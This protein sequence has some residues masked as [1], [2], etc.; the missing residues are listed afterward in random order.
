MVPIAKILLRAGLSYREFDDVCRL[1][2]VQV[3]SSEFGVRN[4]STNFSRISALTGISRKE[5]SRLSAGDR[6]LDFSMRES[7]SPLADIVQTWSGNRDF[8]D[9]H[10]HPIPLP[11]DGDGITFQELV[12]RTGGDYPIGAIRK[13]LLRMKVVRFDDEG[14]VI[15]LRSDLIP[16]DLDLRVVSSLTYSLAGLAETIAFNCTIRL[17]EETTRVERYIESRLM[18]ED[19]VRRAEQQIGRILRDTTSQLSQILNAGDT[20]T[21]APV[22]RIG[23]GLYYCE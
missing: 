21:A 6:K 8:L 12:R 15:L 7:L 11:E 9:A 3:A 22:R 4:R 18:S 13:E 16:V 2:F 5:V 17:P 23:V 19:E 1:A 14:Q 10:G 20:S